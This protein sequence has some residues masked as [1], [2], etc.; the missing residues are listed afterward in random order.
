MSGFFPRRSTL[1]QPPLLR[2]PLARSALPASASARSSSA[3]PAASIS[4]PK[5]APG[6]DAMK[7]QYKRPATIPFPKENPYTPEKT[8]LGKKLYFDTRLSVT[9]AQSCASCHSP[10]FGWGDG[11]AVGVGHGMAKARP[12]FADHRQCRVG[13]DLHVGRPAGNPRRAGARS[14]PGRRR[15]EH[16]ARAMMERLTS[17]GEYK[18]LF[19]AAFPDEGM[20]TKTLAKAIA[21]YE[22]PWS[23]SVR[24]SIHGSRAMRKR[25]PR[26]PS[27]A[28]PS[29]TARRSVLPAMRA[30]TSP[31][32]ASRTSAAEQGCRPRRVHAG[33][34]QDAARFQDAWLARNRAPEPLYARWIARHAGS[35]G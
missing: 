3:K 23:P 22:R 30:G 16:A 20:S 32:T 25:F 1:L 27:A 7:A 5:A 34:D 28:L 35:G 26:K 24:R 13:R 29:S 2:P 17:I 33:R 12:P 14:D 8:A 21:T 11:L 15:D 9:S 18:P 4:V 19:L 10:G 6:I 31:M